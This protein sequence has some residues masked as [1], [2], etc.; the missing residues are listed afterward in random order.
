MKNINIPRYIEKLKQGRV[1]F[2]VVNHENSLALKD[3]KHPGKDII[4]L[5]NSIKLK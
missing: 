1:P 3:I 2:Y 4:P 5:T